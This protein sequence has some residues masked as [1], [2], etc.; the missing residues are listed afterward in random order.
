MK[1][2][3][4]EIGFGGA[5][6]NPFKHVCKPLPVAVQHAKTEKGARGFLFMHEGK[7]VPGT[8][9]LLRCKCG[10]VSTKEL[11]GEWTLEQVNGHNVSSVDKLLASVKP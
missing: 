6:G 11:I 8:V 2:K 9:V 7:E 5:V 10:A 4:L 3:L 1:L